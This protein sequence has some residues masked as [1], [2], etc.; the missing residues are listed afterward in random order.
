VAAI[1]AFLVI[2]QEGDDFVLEVNVAAARL[3]HKFIA[4]RRIAQQ[5]VMK[6]RLNL[7]PL[8]HSPLLPHRLTHGAATP[9]RSSNPG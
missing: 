6:N 4:L 2:G 8:I 9:G 7:A 5:G 1:A 3:A